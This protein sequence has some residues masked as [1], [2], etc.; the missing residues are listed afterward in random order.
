MNGD[1]GSP[2]M[3]MEF[4]WITDRPLDRPGYSSQWAFFVLGSDGLSTGG[5]PGNGYGLQ[6]GDNSD[7]NSYAFRWAGGYP[8]PS[9]GAASIVEPSDLPVHWL[10]TLTPVVGGFRHLKV[11][12]N[13]GPGWQKDLVFDTGYGIDDLTGWYI[14][15]AGGSIDNLVVSAGSV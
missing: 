1:I 3:T 11:Q 10:V 9:S 2:D 14:D 6:K 5:P 15:T 4:D 7:S 8:S 13:G 12:I